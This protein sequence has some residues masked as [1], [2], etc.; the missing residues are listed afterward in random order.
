MTPKERRAILTRACDQ[1][2]MAGV[3]RSNIKLCGSHAGVSIGEDG[4]SQ[5]GLEDLAMFRAVYGSTVLYPCD[6]NQTAQLVA[7]MADH[8]GIVYMRTTREKT[9]V[10]YTPDEQFTVRPEIESDGGHDLR[11]GGHQLGLEAGPR[12]QRFE[13]C[14]RSHRGRIHVLRLG[15]LRSDLGKRRGNEQQ[16]NSIDTAGG[17]SGPQRP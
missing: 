13:R 17:G 2:R 12:L 4:P 11:L 16:R 1:I 3:S 7:Q 6:P 9:P 10:L 8:G 14:L 5:M 15:G